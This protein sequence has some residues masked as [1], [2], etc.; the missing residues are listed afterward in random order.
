MALY[1]RLPD[2]LV[3]AS[4]QEMAEPVYNCPVLW[5]EEREARDNHAL[6]LPLPGDAELCLEKGVA[7]IL[8][9]RASN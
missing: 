6:F 9:S 1:S 8:K 7:I 4:A 2:L 3:R 5:T